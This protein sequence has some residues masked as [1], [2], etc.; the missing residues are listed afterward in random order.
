LRIRIVCTF[1]PANHRLWTWTAVAA[2]HE[3]AATGGTV[4]AT[5]QPTAAAMAE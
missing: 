3:I 4:A 1:P 5:G 2:T